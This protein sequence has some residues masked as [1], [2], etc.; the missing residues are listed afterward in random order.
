M[1]ARSMRRRGNRGKEENLRIRTEGPRASGDGE[2]DRGGQRCTRP[3]LR[4]G[5]WQRTTKQGRKS[6][7]RKNKQRGKKKTQSRCI[8]S[9]KPWIIFFFFS[10]FSNSLCIFCVFFLSPPPPEGLAGHS[11]NSYDYFRKQ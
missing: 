2:G 1:A 9:R 11:L 3:I 10:S 8:F 4:A 7:G 6:G 5:P